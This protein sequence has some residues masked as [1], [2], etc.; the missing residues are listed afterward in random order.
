VSSLVRASAARVKLGRPVTLSGV[1]RADPACARP[2]RVSVLKRAYGEH[3]APLSVVA[4]SVAVGRDGRWSL[5]HRPDRTAEYAVVAQPTPTCSSGNAATT[6]VAVTARILL[7]RGGRCSRAGELTGRVRPPQPGTTV[8]LQRAGASGFR[9]IARTRLDG[10]SR[11]RFA[12]DCKR[13]HRIVW[14][15]EN[16]RNAGTRSTARR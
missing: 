13:R 14:R 3:D 8:Q 15:G 5:R 9:T 10:A 11:F 6:T 16:R 12:V 4:T 7:D 2:F 1:V